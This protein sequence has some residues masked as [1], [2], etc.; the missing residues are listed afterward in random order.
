MRVTNEFP[1]K[2]DV[3]SILKFYRSEKL[4]GELVI[5]LPGNG[6]ISN[7]EFREKETRSEIEAV[8]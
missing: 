6:G 5:S 8:E 1:S 2:A 7:I 4:A 3:A